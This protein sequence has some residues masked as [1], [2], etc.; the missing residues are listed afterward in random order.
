MFWV[1]DYKAHTGCCLISTNK[2]VARSETWFGDQENE[3][4]KT[5]YL[6]L[7][8][9]IISK[10]TSRFFGTESILNFAISSPHLNHSLSEH[11]RFKAYICSLVLASYGTL[12]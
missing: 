10:R 2:L 9:A 7:K 5:K 6:K 4:N 11:K 8:S 1:M 3:V 12:S